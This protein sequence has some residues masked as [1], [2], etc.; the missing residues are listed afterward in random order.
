MVDES[1]VVEVDLGAD[2]AGEGALEVEAGVLGGAV[3]FGA[4]TASTCAGGSGPKA[5]P[6]FTSMSRPIVPHTTAPVRSASNQNHQRLTSGL[7]GGL[8]GRT[9]GA[10]TVLL[11]RRGIDA[12]IFAGKPCAL[13]GS[14][15]ARRA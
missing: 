12:W 7:H 4:A 5:R 11:G 1:G 3:L 6:M 2:A 14:S 9:N 8:G 13:H 15:R 10:V